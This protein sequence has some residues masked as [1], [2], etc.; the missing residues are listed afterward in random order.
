MKLSPR[1]PGENA[2]TYVHNIILDNIISLE[3]PPG[4]AVS[5]NELSLSLQVSRTPV[6]EALIEMSRMGLIEILPQKGSFVTKIDGE[7][8][9]EAQFMRL[10]LE[11]SVMRLACRQGIPEHCFKR[12]KENL[13]RQKELLHSPDAYSAF[14]ELDNLFHKLLFESVSKLRTYEFLKHQM[15]HFDRLRTLTYQ[16]MKDSKTAQTINDHEN[17]L[18]ALE[19]KDSELA[20]LVMTLHL[21]RHQNEIKKLS[22]F[23]PEYFSNI[24]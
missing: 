10:S 5:E 1:V 9:E 24:R 8:I 17:I 7:L 23:Y 16:T 2:R 18:Y 20:E 12:M 13:E 4:T 15:V 6:R 14:L 21:T 19:K 11:T 3:L 22:A